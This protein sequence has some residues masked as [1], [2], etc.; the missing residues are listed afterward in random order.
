MIFMSTEVTVTG[1][2]WVRLPSGMWPVTVTL[3]T[4]A[5]GQG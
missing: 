2:H 1:K 4:P 3:D 5:P